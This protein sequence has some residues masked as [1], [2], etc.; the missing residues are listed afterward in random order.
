MA[1]TPAELRQ[2]G[3]RQP[4]LPQWQVAKHTLLVVHDDDTW[5]GGDSEEKPPQKKSRTS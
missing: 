4:P 1:A 2:P 5:V 3:S